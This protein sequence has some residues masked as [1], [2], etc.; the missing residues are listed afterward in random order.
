MCPLCNRI[1]IACSDITCSSCIYENK[2]CAD[3]CD[4]LLENVII[5]LYS[6][7]IQSKIENSKLLEELTYL[8]PL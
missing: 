2:D 5:E 3:E 6:Q 7:L 8:F 4:C 1:L